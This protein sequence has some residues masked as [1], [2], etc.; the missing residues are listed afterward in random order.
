MLSFQFIILCSLVRGFRRFLICI[1]GPRVLFASSGEIWWL[2]VI[3]L[4]TVAGGSVRKRAEMSVLSLSSSVLSLKVVSR[5]PRRLVEAY[6]SNCSGL[7]FVMEL[8]LLLSET[9]FNLT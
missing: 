7:C 9:S 1:W 6:F 3:R 5:L 8:T 4:L 2:V